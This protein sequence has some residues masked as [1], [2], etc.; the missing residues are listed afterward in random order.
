MLVP[1]RAQSIPVEGN[2]HSRVRVVIYEDLQCPDCANF[3]EM[4][5]QTLLPQFQST[6]AFEHRDFP[7]AKHAYARKEA[8]AARFFA[9]I[10]AQTAVEFRRACFAH[11]DEVRAGGFDQLLAKFS[12]GHNI[13]PA[14]ATAALT[15]QKLNALVEADFEDGVARGIAHTPTVLVDGEPFIES[16]PAADVVKSIEKALAASKQ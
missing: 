13:D 2:P 5:D 10:S 8:V 3:R 12:T 16:F 7:L 4:L 11:I 6:V 1:A 9:S 14:K 15:D